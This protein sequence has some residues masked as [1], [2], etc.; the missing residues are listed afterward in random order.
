M[1]LGIKAEQLTELGLDDQSAGQLIQQLN[2]VL[3]DCTTPAQAWSAI[4][5]NILSARLPFNIHSLLYS[6]T[7]PDWHEHPDTAPAYIPDQSIKNNANITKFMTELDIH[8]VKTF[9]RWSVTNYPEFWSRIIAKL[10]IVFKT[11]PEH[12]CD[13]SEGLEAPHWLP[14]AKLNITDSCFTSPPQNTAI[15][16]EDEKKQIHKMSYG[17]LNRLSNRIANSLIKQGLVA[18]DAIGIAMPMNQYA[19][20]IYLGIIKMGGIVV[21]IADSFSS[22]EIA[23][24]LRIANAKAVFTQDVTIWAHKK[25]PLYAKVAEANAKRIFVLP[26]EKQVSI[27]LRKEDVAWHDFLVE[28]SE[29]TSVAL[30]PMTGCNILFSSGTTADPKAIVWNH[31]T[32]IKAASDAFFHHNIHSG[33]VIA[34]PTNLGWMMGPWLIYASLINHATMALYTEAPKDRV[35]GEFIQHAKVN[36]LGVVPTAVASWRQTHCMDGLNWSMIKVFTSTG[37]CSNPND[38][39]YLMSLAGYK[40]VI[41]YCGG[42]EIGG[43]YLSS[44]VIE[45]NCPSLFSTP[46]MGMN[47]IILNE[48]GKP[49]TEG[50]VAIIPPSMGLSPSC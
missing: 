24:R 8:D 12:I 36:M 7:Y 50:E 47:L 3:T 42:T 40:P 21:S 35:F 28:N 18:G 31:S 10:G 29:F 13:L 26:A 30:N 6:L 15:V 19:V 39:L 17:E 11:K 37:E 16:Y 9:H 46:A 38:M 5:K 44:T 49:A 22:Q 27:S 14:G 34:W 48:D 1:H 20:A 41:E 32:P 43:A 25:I 2:S 23:T 45:N 33:D 4:T